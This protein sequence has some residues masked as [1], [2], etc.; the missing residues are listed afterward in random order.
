MTKVLL[1][2]GH[3]DYDS[4]AVGQGTT[5][6][7]ENIQLTDRTAAKLRGYGVEVVVMPHTIGDLVAEINWANANAADADLGVQIHKNS[8]GGTGVE[9]W[10]P[11][12]PTQEM[13][14][15]SATINNAMCEATGLA[16]RGVKFAQN[17]RW[18]KL[19]WCDDTVFPA[20][21]VECGFI[22]VDSNGD[23][24]DDQMS[25]GLAKGIALS[26]GVSIAP[27]T[28]PTPVQEPAQITYE[29]ITPKEI[30]LIR[31]TQ[32]WN[33]AFTSWARAQAVKAYAQGERIKVVAIAT[34]SLGAR[35]YMSEWSYNG[36]IIRATNGFNVNDCRDYVAPAP[37][38]EPTPEPAPTPAPEVEPTTEP[39]PVPTPAPQE[40]PTENKENAMITKEQALKIAKTAAYVGISALIGYILSFVQGNVEMFGIYAPIINIILVTLKQVFATQETK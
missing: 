27:I 33:F 5:E 8:G 26:L 25:S 3:G 32:L 10:T 6:R 39:T 16:N 4:G 29:V 40:T 2:A 7:D 37:T 22:D 12:Y 13:I 9:T 34:N 15:L 14:D 21:L 11:S 18:G 17:N 24:M 19:G 30:E 20:V 31:D 1:S 38:P 23:A 35:Y 36:G 28:A